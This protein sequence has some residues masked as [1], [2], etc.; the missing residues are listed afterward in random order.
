MIEGQLNLTVDR[1]LP[2]LIR[3][4]REITAFMEQYPVSE[5][6]RFD[7]LV[8]VEE[9]VSNIIRHGA[10]GT[11]SPITLR[12]RMT[13]EAMEI[14]LEDE[15]PAFNPLAHPQPRFDLPLQ[16]RSLGGLGIFI[17]RQLMNTVH[18][19]RRNGNNC[20]TMARRLDGPG[21]PPEGAGQSDA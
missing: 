15:G 17:V 12:A 11:Q 19:E 8:S 5:D 20:F 1:K 7:V 21:M 9:M 18:Y 10:A 3:V 16:E 4:N 13:S 14:Q 2:E 6:C